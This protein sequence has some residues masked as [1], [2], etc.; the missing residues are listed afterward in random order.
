[1]KRFLAATLL[2]PLLTALLLAPLAVLHPDVKGHPP[3][4]GK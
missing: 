4:G 3:A 2:F 1:M